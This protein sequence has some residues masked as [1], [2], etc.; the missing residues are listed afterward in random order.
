MTQALHTLLEHAQRQRDEALA[1]L[2]QAESAAEQMRL[3]AEQ[4]LSFQGEYDARHPARSGRSAP[5]E[6]LR[7]HV[8]FMQRLHQAQTQQKGQL[9]AAQ[10]RVVRQKQA[11]M[12]MEM[13]LAAVRKLVDRRSQERQ[14]TANTL[15][16]RRH[17]E[18]AQQRAWH[19]RADTA[20]P[21][22]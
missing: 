2:Q 5:I 4:L 11:L 6:L 16:Q 8:G 9:Q 14:R 7:C 17:D 20:S 1:A 15:E 18:A 22:Y 3:Q 13:R 19:T 10:A 21:Q 12:A